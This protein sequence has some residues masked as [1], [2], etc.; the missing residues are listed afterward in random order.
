MQCH[1]ILYDHDND[2]Q[3][4]QSMRCHIVYSYASTNNN[5]KMEIRK[6]VIHARLPA[7]SDNHWQKLLRLLKSNV[8]IPPLTQN[9][10]CGFKIGVCTLVPCSGP[11]SWY[12]NL[13]SQHWFRGNS[14][15]MIIKGWLDPYFLTFKQKVSIF[16]SMVVR[17]CKYRWLLFYTPFS[18]PLP[19]WHKIWTAF[20]VK[21]GER[22]HDS[23]TP[24]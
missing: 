12:I 6:F 7:Y 14:R 5:E 13:N 21:K 8:Y 10:C 17:F 22:R 1:F 11:Y 9:Q 20:I 24:L 19:W 4:N 18:F 3:N 2:R 23:F 16:L 15:G